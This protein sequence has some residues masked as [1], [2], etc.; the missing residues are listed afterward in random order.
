MHNGSVARTQ[1]SEACLLG[2]GIAWDMTVLR[3][4]HGQILELLLPPD[5]PNVTGTVLYLQ[6]YLEHQTKERPDKAYALRIWLRDREIRAFRPEGSVWRPIVCYHSVLLLLQ[7]LNAGLHI[8]VETGPY[9][10]GTP[11]SVLSSEQMPA[12]RWGEQDTGE[13]VSMPE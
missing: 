4:L 1:I 7:L 8:D 5:R 13:F 9:Q 2:L 6:D 12:T 3:T 11:T 10:Q